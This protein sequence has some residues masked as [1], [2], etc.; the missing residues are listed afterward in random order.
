MV[1]TRLFKDS[2]HT[3]DMY[4]YCETRRFDNGS[5]YSVRATTRSH[6]KT[7][8]RTKVR[9]H[10][11]RYSCVVTSIFVYMSLGSDWGTQLPK[12]GYPSTRRQQSARTNLRYI[13][14][15]STYLIDKWNSWN[16]NANVNLFTPLLT[17]Y[18]P[19]TI[20]IEIFSFDRWFERESFDRH[21]TS[22]LL[23][24]SFVLRWWKRKAGE[25]L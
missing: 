3:H 25:N 2:F 8:R 16:R 13:V 14:L 15:I 23:V 6:T 12:A 21:V 22:L 11:W 7:L 20:P 19:T 24:P 9:I 10:R 4:V 17:T 18:C 5:I 1:D